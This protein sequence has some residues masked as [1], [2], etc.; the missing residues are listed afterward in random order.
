MGSLGGFRKHL[1]VLQQFNQ[2]KKK[3]W[4]YEFK[5]EGNKMFQHNI[6]ESI[7]WVNFAK[8][9]WCIF[10][11][12]ILRKPSWK[13]RSVLLVFFFL[14]ILM[15]SSTFCLSWKIWWFCLL[16]PRFLKIWCVLEIF[17]KKITTSSLSRV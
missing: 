8:Y 16:H 7:Q 13:I 3:Y 5:K 11:Y 9:L 12:K 4:P 10:S 2:S 1:G 15:C 6:D 14:E 17:L